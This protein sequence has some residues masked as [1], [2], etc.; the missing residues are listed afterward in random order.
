MNTRTMGSSSRLTGRLLVFVWTAFLMSAVAAKADPTKTLVQ[1]TLYR[2][3][4]SVATGTVTIRWEGFSTSAG[5]AVPSGQ[6]T[7]A[8]GVNGGISIPLIPNTGSSPAGSYYRVVI[9]LKDGTTSEE[10]WVVPVAATTTISAI[11]AKVVPQAVAA[12]FVG[13]DYVDTAVSRLSSLASP[14]PIGAVTPGLVNATAVTAQS[15]N[16]VANAAQFAGADWAAKVM[17][18]IGTLPTQG[19]TV[20]VPSSLSG[21]TSAAGITLP[22]GVSIQFDA[23]TFTAGGPITLEGSGHSVRGMGRTATQLAFSGGTDGLV[24]LDAG[25]VYK[26]TIIEN[27]TLASTNAAG[28]AAFR[29]TDS[30]IAAAISVVMRNVTVTAEGTGKWAYG[31]FLANAQFMGFYDMLIT[32]AVNVGIHGENSVNEDLFVNVFVMNTNGFRG[33]EFFPGPINNCEAYFVNG[34]IQGVFSGSALLNSGSYVSIFGMHFETQPV[35]GSSYS[36]GASIV[37]ADG[38]LSATAAGMSM[39]ILTTFTTTN[40]VVQISG[41]QLGDVTLDANTLGSI[42]SSNA[43]SITNNSSSVALIGNT[44]WGGGGLINTVTVGNLTMTPSSGTGQT[45]W[46]QGGVQSFAITRA[47]GGSR[48]TLGSGFGLGFATSGVESEDTYLSR[49]GQG[50][51]R[52]G[53]TNGGMDGTF[54]ASKFYAGAATWTSGSGAPTG[55]CTNGSMYS[56]T[57]TG[58]V[59]VCQGTVWGGA[60]VVSFAA[61]TA[62][63]GGSA[64]AVGCT[65]QSP[66]TVTGA[67]TSMACVMSGTEGNPVN[68]HPQCAVTGANTVTPQLCTAVA[69]TPAAQTYNIRVIQ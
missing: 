3:D 27:L 44:S 57:D 8:T 45:I 60:Q 47:A 6:L 22:A 31:L 51:V 25:P 65:N 63:I 66:I 67:T 24:I 13:R 46:A 16:G 35:D 68:V 62:S 1:D 17:A 30:T 10:Q 50:E 41:S 56:R 15:V 53:T 11:R 34:G 42:V 55:S 12:Q 4:G 54:K 23:G 59:Y 39:P 38:H 69:A 21:G 33:A 26:D 40:P 48:F 14:G 36:D 61:T 43:K 52:V 58:T 32:G 2:A 28:G 49:D 18:A 29:A 19:G 7:V 5:E 64:L 9:K 37:V 20:F